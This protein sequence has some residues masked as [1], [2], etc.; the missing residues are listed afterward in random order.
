MNTKYNLGSKRGA[1][2]PAFGSKD[3][4]RR[5]TELVDSIDFG[6][7]SMVLDGEFADITIKISIDNN[8]ESKKELRLNLSAKLRDIRKVLN[9]KTDIRMGT[10]AFFIGKGGGEISLNV[11][12][13]KNLKDIVENCVLKINKRTNEIDWDE[14]IEI[15]KLEYGYDFNDNKT[16]SL[17]KKLFQFKNYP[18]PEA[19]ERICNIEKYS[20][21]C[22]DK[23]DDLRVKNNI[24]KLKIG[25]N[26]PWL[27]IC[28]D[29]SI[30][31]NKEGR[32]INEN[33]TVYRIV[34]RVHATIDI[35]E[36]E[37]YPTED[38]KK[39]VE[40]ALLEN[41]IQSKRAALKKVAE[42]FGPFWSRRILLG[43]KIICQEN[44]QNCLNESQN[45]NQTSVNLNITKNGMG[46]SRNQNS[47]SSYY[48]N[49]KFS[50]VRAYG[51]DDYTGDE[52]E[53]IESLKNY[54]KWS[55]IEYEEIALVFDV[56]DKTTR[57]K[58]SALFDAT[59]VKSGVENINFKVNKKFKNPY[60]THFKYG[61]N[62]TKSHRI[63][64]SVINQKDPKEIFALRL[65]YNY[66]STMPQIVLNRLGELTSSND[67]ITCCL[68]LAWIV[69]GPSYDFLSNNVDKI[70]CGEAK[71]TVNG[72]RYE[73]K[74]LDVD[75]NDPNDPNNSL[76]LT[77]VTRATEN[78]DH[79]PKKSKIVVGSHFHSSNSKIRSCGFC[80]DVHT[81]EQK[82]TSIDKVDFE[83][84]YCAIISDESNPRFGMSSVSQR[85]TLEKKE[86][87]RIIE[88]SPSPTDIKNLIACN[89]CKNLDNNCKHSI[90]LNV[91]LEDCTKNCTPGFLNISSDQTL[92]YTY[93][94]SFDK[95]AQIVYYSPL[96]HEASEN[97]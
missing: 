2:E 81:G 62:L 20:I 76:I 57:E 10:N 65:H 82:L 15:C 1:C 93:K 70:I 28:L 40:N 8:E 16:K 68:K 42:E 17:K 31:S 22:R 73:T 30:G 77:C 50:Y 37:A 41:T 38:F 6:V 32:K 74:E 47:S 52:K 25:S 91:L 89:K 72:E 26:L 94:K 4:K 23:F 66:G 36:L 92:F 61:P 51:G 55:P 34:Q 45:N 33:S 19:L 75:P 21:E 63:F 96:I 7:N 24:A 97:N 14:V 79:D 95:D 86:K 90:F 71:T 9:I 49:S 59:I 43:G 56:L 83:I 87:A 80:Y 60:V 39:A 85:S 58:I 29:F 54:E 46:H 18:G 3:P 35:S 69:I 64:A 88:I 67:I 44:D 13:E 12:H 11:E 53:W 48:T 27:P 78:S 84:N 5:A